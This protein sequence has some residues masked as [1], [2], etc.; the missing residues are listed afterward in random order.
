MARVDARAR[1]GAGL[2]DALAAW[3]RE[4]RAPGLAAAAGALAL[5]STV[6]GRAA[7][8]LE[9]LAASLRDRLAVAAEA[10]RSRRRHGPRRWV[11]GA[12]PIGYLAYSALADPRALHALIGTTT[13][14]VCAA[15]GLGL[16]ALGALWMRRILAGGDGAGRWAMVSAATGWG[17]ACGVIAALPLLGRARRVETRERSRAIVARRARVTFRRR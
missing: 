10:A 6:G 4:R 13:G 11:V 2:S 9:E 15:I 16:E 7:D 12:A 3:P 1:L 8:A 14:R 17:L 5:S